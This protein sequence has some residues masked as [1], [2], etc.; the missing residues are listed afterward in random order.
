MKIVYHR[1]QVNNDLL[2]F[3]P[4]QP[5]ALKKLMTNSVTDILPKG[6]CQGVYFSSYVDEKM[7][8][9]SANQGGSGQM[10]T[11][12]P[13]GLRFSHTNVRI[14]DTRGHLVCVPTDI[15]DYEHKGGGYFEGF[16]KIDFNPE[17]NE[18][19]IINWEVIGKGIPPCGE[20]IFVI[21][22]ENAC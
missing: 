10:H 22:T 16:K 12:L 15:K 18:R 4:T 9:N 5:E 3:T 14:E 21:E 7:L 13:Q 6:K 11:A 19:I 20:F 8:N 1:V 2:S 17:E